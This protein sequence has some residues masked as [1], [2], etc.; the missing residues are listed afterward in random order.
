MALPS[1]LHVLQSE[2]HETCLPSSI[3][4]PLYYDSVDE[5]LIA[6][7]ESLEVWSVKRRGCTQCD[8]ISLKLTVR[9]GNAPRRRQSSPDEEGMLLHTGSVMI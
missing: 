1:G 4:Q 9:E 7:K 6:R 3:T 5:Y 8:R 2:E